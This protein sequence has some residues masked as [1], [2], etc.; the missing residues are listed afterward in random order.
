MSN[1]IIPR[2]KLDTSLRRWD[3]P[4][5]TDISWVPPTLPPKVT[6][7]PLASEP[8]KGSSAAPKQPPI[9]PSSTHTKHSEELATSMSSGKILSQ[10]DLGTTP[11]RWEPQRVDDI[12][13]TPTPTAAFAP[14]V[15]TSLTFPSQESISP[16]PQT[17]PADED[18]TETVK[19]PT[20]E[21]IEALSQDAYQEGFDR[22][23]QDGLTQGFEQGQ[24]DGLIEGQA[25]GFQHGHEEGLQQGLSEGLQQGIEQGFDQGRHDGF[26]EGHQDG[27]AQG[28]EEGRRNGFA[29]GLDEGRKEGLVQG[30]E[31]GR[32]EG[33]AQGLEEGRKE[34][35]AQ[36]IEEGRH[37]GLAKGDAELQDKLERLGQLLTQLEQPLANLDREVEEQLVALTVAMTR[38]IVRRELVHGSS[39]IIPVLREALT[40]L[41]SAHRNLRIFLHPDDIPLVRAAL[42][43]K[44]VE[45][46]ARLEEDTNITQGG[47]RVETDDSRIDI[48][49]EN[50]INQVIAKLLGGDQV[51]D[52]VPPSASG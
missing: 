9:K 40:S 34:G 30:L 13:W 29:Q 26:E 52:S 45:Y 17:S 39:A 44:T 15:P 8:H 46:E 48:T 6:A 3:P 10:E 7:P 1:S 49:V 21:E 38:Q 37:E 51:A 42:T 36:G 31:E 50:R 25:T 19:L 33:L 11:R 43:T 32:R 28:L 12:F 5:I 23:H 22:G 47:C 35:L 2:E 4:G 16:S 41:P 20:V 24:R 14:F 18:N 27:L